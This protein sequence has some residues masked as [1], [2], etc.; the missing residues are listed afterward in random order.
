MVTCCDVKSLPIVHYWKKKRIVSYRWS[1]AVFSRIW[2]CLE[3]NWCNL[4]AENYLTSY[5]CQTLKPTNYLF[6]HLSDVKVM[7]EADF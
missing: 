6:S 7:S 1:C 5:G 2:I 3:C 4:R